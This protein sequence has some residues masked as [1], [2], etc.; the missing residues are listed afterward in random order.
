MHSA[1]LMMVRPAGEVPEHIRPFV[2]FDAR[3]RDIDLTDGDKVAVVHIATTQSYI[4][5]PLGKGIT[6]ESVLSELSETDTRLDGD[7]QKSLAA[8]LQ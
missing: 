4:I 3:R 5:V 7:S 6:L 1:Y 8:L 2:Q